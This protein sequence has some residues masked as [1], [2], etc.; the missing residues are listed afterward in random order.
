MTLPFRRRHHDDETGH[1]RARVTW[2]TAF[3]EDIDPA[4]QAWLVAHLAGCGECRVELEAQLEDRLLLRS[5]RDQPIDPPRDLWA[6]TSAAIERES[7]RRS[8]RGQPPV[9]IADR[10]FPRSFRLPVGAIAGLLV[11]AVVIATSL[12]PH[13]LVP[14]EPTPGGSGVAAIS[15]AAAPSPIAVRTAALGWLQRSA[16]GTYQYVLADVDQVCPNEASGCAPLSVSDAHTSAL[17]LSGQPQSVVSSADNSQ[18]VVV[19]GSGGSSSGSVIVVPVPT[20]APTGSAAPT[21]SVTPTPAPTG[22]AA[23][24]ASVTP[25][26]SVRPTVSPAGSGTPAPTPVATPVGARS[27]AKGVTVVGETAYSPDGKW[28]AF[29][30][31]PLDGSTGPDLYLWNVS[32]PT[33]VAITS[34]H[35]TFFSGWFGGRILASRISGEPIAGPKI[36]GSPSPSIDPTGEVHPVSFLVDPATHAMVDFSIPDVWLPTVDASG[37]FAAYWLGTLR[38]DGTGSGW[39]PATGRLVLDGWSAPLGS[40]TQAGSPANPAPTSSA[41]AS[42]GSAGAAPN[43]A[44][45]PAGTPVTLVNGPIAG[46]EARFDPTGS[47]LA[48]WVA[49]PS[50]PTVGN[51]QLV[52]LDR[53]HGNVDPKLRPLPAVRALRGISIDEGRVAWVTPP[54]QD[55]QK[56]VVQVLAWSHD[57]FGQVETIPAEQLTLVH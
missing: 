50:D 23:P 38:P 45:G 47:R 39:V 48:V 21:A 51:L 2:S 5:L 41:A 54:G 56:S 12:A 53:G 37:R 18:I 13:G 35:S 20:P 57:E 29:S 34:D 30:A 22:S 19:A 9:Q 26:P 33:A 11:A 55:G 43:P 3:L 16:D 15:P 1:D 8:R 40:Q 44:G 46:F 49:D 10:L 32:D 24:T 36:S 4:D 31:R 14:A 17:T 27:I 7:G 42:H 52:V 28:L 25:T 6:R